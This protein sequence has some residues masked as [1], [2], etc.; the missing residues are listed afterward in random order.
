MFYGQRDGKGK[1]SLGLWYNGRCGWHASLIFHGVSHHLDDTVVERLC[2]L[3]LLRATAAVE[4]K[5]DGLL[6]LNGG[7]RKM[8]E[9]E[10]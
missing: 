1:G 7:H 6:G 5:V 9:E 4:D 3:R 8:L 10:G 2:D